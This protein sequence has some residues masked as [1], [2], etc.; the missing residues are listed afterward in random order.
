M[1]PPPCV[2]VRAFADATQ[3]QRFQLDGRKLR[4]GMIAQSRKQRERGAVD[5]LVVGV[6]DLTRFA[7]RAHIPAGFLRIG[8]PRILV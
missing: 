7:L 5:G 6:N 8:V 2:T 4:I 3:A 1:G